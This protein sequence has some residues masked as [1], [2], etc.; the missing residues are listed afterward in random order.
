MTTTTYDALGGVLTTS[1]VLGDTTTN[2][3]D[4]FHRLYTVT[5][6]DG[7]SDTTTYTYDSDGNLYQEEDADG[8]TT[9]Y[10]YNALNWQTSMTDQLGHAATSAYDADGNLVQSVDRDGQEIDYIYDALN[11]ETG[12][13]WINS[14]GS[15]FRTITTNYYSNGLVSSVTDTGD[16]NGQYVDYGYTY[17][18]IGLAHGR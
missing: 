17:D 18:S 12:E 2:T 14:S 16:T 13:N 5:N 15:A 6:P 4:G 3:Y 1:D 8:N 10:G 11:R 9:T 7:G